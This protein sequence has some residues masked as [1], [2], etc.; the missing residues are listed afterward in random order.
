MPIPCYLI[1]IHCIINERFIVLLEIQTHKHT[2]FN[3]HSGPDLAALEGWKEGV[4]AK[5]LGCSQ[6]R[7]QGCL[8][9]SRLGLGCSTSPLGNLGLAL[10]CLF[11]GSTSEVRATG[12]QKARV[13]NLPGAKHKNAI[14]FNLQVQRFTEIH[15]FNSYQFQK[16]QKHTEY[17]NT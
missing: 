13:R 9:S 2:I 10:L 15:A 12:I 11:T 8:Q 17:I 14:I 5:L 6:V 4:P 16:P 3:S 7:W 1:H